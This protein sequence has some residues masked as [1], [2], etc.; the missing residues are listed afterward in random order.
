MESHFAHD[1]P[2][3]DSDDERSVLGSGTFGKVFRMLFEDDNKLYT[4][5]EVRVKRA[6]DTNIDLGAVMC[7]V[8]IL[9][10]LT[11]AHIIRYFKCYFSRKEKYFNVI[12]EYAN[13]G[14]LADQ[15]E[16]V[17]VP[18]LAT[19]TRWLKESLSALE[20]LHG[21]RILHRDIKP[22]NIWLQRSEV[23]SIG[24]ESEGEVVYIIK[25]ADLG[26]VT[27]TSAFAGL[28]T[29]TDIDAYS[30][31]EKLNGAQYDSSD[32]IW[33]LG[34][35]FAELLTCRRLSGKR[36]DSWG[37][38]M[39]SKLAEMQPRKQEVLRACV[40]ANAEIGGLVMQMLSENPR[41]RP[42]AA[43]LLRALT[44]VQYVV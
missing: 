5:K 2:Q 10:E 31:Y 30:S 24:R 36:R 11:H 13:S 7:E 6:R 34:C 21:R 37:V 40:D 41:E 27:V 22:E 12:M 38:C 3:E 26:L 42:D 18:T 16:C 33:G 44:Q 29:K 19:V 20:Y 28:Q 25:L 17:P 32:D 35:V 14:S 8:D 39:F 9:S 43:L 4:V 23:A 1:P 15:I